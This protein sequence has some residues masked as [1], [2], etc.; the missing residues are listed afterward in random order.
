MIKELLPQGLIYLFLLIMPTLA[1]SND[2]KGG[3]PDTVPAATSIPP[4]ALEAVQKSQG[5]LEVR[6]ER[7]DGTVTYHRGSGFL[8]DAKH[9]IVVAST[10]TMPQFKAIFEG[11]DA[12]TFYKVYDDNTVQKVSAYAYATS[13]ENELTIFQLDGAIPEGMDEIVF[14]EALPQHRPVYA[15]IP[16]VSGAEQRAADAGRWEAS[17]FRG[18]IVP[19]IPAHDTPPNR[20]HPDAKYIYLDPPVAL[21]ELWH[22]LIPCH[23]SK[24]FSKATMR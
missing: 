2:E 13:S 9:G 8:V 14:A 22:R 21:F 20:V 24:R 17:D 5:V 10:H 1:L 12:V 23:N 18:H 6:M 11:D 15:R 3:I 16:R 19:V 4:M 7:L